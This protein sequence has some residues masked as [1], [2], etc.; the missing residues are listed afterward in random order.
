MTVGFVSALG[1]SLPVGSGVIGGASYT[2]P[3]V[4]QTDAP[5]NP[6]NS[7]GVLVDAEGRL[8]GVP[9]AI[10]SPVRANAGIGFAVPA[11]IVERVV[12][13]LI[14]GGAYEHPWLGISGMTLNAELAEAMDLDSDQRGVL[15]GEVVA[16]GPAEAAGLRGG[17]R[18]VELSG[19]PVQVGGDVI[20]AINDQE[21]TEF[22]D[23]VSYLA[24]STRVGEEITLTI[25]R[26][27]EQQQVKVLLAAR[28]TS[29]ERPAAS[30][31]QVPQTT[32][33]AWLGIM[34][35]TLTTAI[36]EAMDIDADQKGVLVEQIVRNGP[37][38]E[39][40][41]RGGYSQAEIEGEEIAL[42][43]DVIIAVEGEPVSN[44]EELRAALS[45]AE[46]GDRVVITVLR[47][48]KEQKLRVTLG[49]RP[50]TTP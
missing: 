43:G 10:E 28:P 4:I 40:D 1:R 30:A 42:G 31:E 19:Q 26:D 46:P 2:I 14:S 13:A 7:G 22:E 17:N 21:V 6:G 18:E 49:E 36:A 15:V 45:E 44:M 32:G 38:D 50:E 5:I 3:D 25:L 8:I 29:E 33:G 41:L 34:G 47:D 24:S 27:R 16:G 9:T 48:G 37:A 11:A 12:P 20:I 35:R 39:A 23:L